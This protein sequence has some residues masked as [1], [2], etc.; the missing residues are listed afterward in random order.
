MKSQSIDQQLTDEQWRLIN[1]LNFKVAI[2]KGELYEAGDWDYW[3]L[4]DRGTM[5]TD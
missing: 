4:S 2:A 1:Y 5:A 3:E